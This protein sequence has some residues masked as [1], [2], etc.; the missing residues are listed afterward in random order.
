ME[1][2][3]FLQIYLEVYADLTTRI[4]TQKPIGP[5][6]VAFLTK[7][8]SPLLS[9]TTDDGSVFDIVISQFHALKERSLNLLQAHIRKEMFEALRYYTNLYSLSR[10]LLNIGF[11]GQAWV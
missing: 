8:L 3:N 11:I 2:L 1:W 10:C 9:T 7:R 5:Y 6:T 4:K